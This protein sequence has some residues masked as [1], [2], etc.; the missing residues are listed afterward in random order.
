MR[1]E[2][3]AEFVRPGKTVRKEADT[4]AED[5]PIENIDKSIQ[6]ISSRLSDE[7]LEMILSKEPVFFERLV[8]ELLNRMGY[9]FDD[10]S[11]IVTKYTGDE[12]IDGIIKEDKFGFNNIYVQAK[13]WNGNVGRPEIQ[14]F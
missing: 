10:D 11:V 2:S 9:A 1:Y 13:R 4:A 6:M 12:D 8:M 5:T 14:N 3:F 7:L